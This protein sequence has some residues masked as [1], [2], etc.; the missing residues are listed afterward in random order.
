LTQRGAVVLTDPSLTYEFGNGQNTTNLLITA[1]AAQTET[2]RSYTPYGV[3]RGASSI[4]IDNRTFLN[5]PADPA[6][7]LDLLG[8]RNYD[9][10]AGRFLQV[11]PLLETTDPTQL[12]GYTYA[13]NN[14]V[15]QSDPA[16]LSADFCA[17][18][19]CAQQTA[20]GVGCADCESGSIDAKYGG[21]IDKRVLPH[22]NKKSS[23]PAP[24]R[25]TPSCG[26]PTKTMARP[27]TKI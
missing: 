10:A 18:I 25:S 14:P 15:G 16:G 11:D 19:T 12:G 5:Q 1:D 3:T 6:T 21:S 24:G 8:A 20:G 2:R 22:L 9:P 13:G 27:R 23:R 17:T 26:G 4:W 7:G